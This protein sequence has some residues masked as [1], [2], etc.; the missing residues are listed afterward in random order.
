MPRLIN[1]QS[2]RFRN[3]LIVS[4]LLLAGWL[5]L[6]EDVPQRLLPAASAA[7]TAGDNSSVEGRL[8]AQALRAN[9]LIAFTRSRDSRGPDIYV[10]NA[11]GANQINLT[12]LA[13]DDYAPDWSPDAKK[14]AFLSLRGG[15]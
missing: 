14:I 2:H 12:N 9:G 8:T 5:V 10:M 7:K 3:R 11:D 15:A 6:P 4:L 1:L 13:G